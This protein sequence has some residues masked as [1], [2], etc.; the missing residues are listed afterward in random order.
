MITNQTPHE[1]C[2][3]HG[4][5][6]FYLENSFY[7]GSG[8]TMDPSEVGGTA[9]SDAPKGCRS[10]PTHPAHDAAMPSPVRVA[11]RLGREDNMRQWNIALMGP[12]QQLAADGILPPTVSHA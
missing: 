9:E 2:R 7:L 8:Q 3:H 12:F 11:Q 1:A 10:A 6:S 4:P 5:T